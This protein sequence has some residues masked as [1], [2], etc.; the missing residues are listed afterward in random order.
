[1]YLAQL[2]DFCKVYQSI[3]FYNN[4]KSHD[5]NEDSLRT[6]LKMFSANFP[7]KDDTNMEDII[8]HLISMPSSSRKM[9]SEVV[10]ILEL[11]LVLPA[12]NATSER[13]F[14]KLRL[15]KTYLRSTMTQGRLNHLMI[16]AIYHEDLDNLDLE[17]MAFKFVERYIFFKFLFKFKKNLKSE[18]KLVKK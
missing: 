3:Q 17:E 15:I 10:K 8:E 1:M 9:I 4:E 13:T 11:I 6:Q 7:Q 18:I 5:F 2:P 14:S 16:C 12:T